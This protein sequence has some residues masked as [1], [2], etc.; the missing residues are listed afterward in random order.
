MNNI[1]FMVLIC[2]AT[3]QL[4][5]IYGTQINTSWKCEKITTERLSNGR[6]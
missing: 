2:L 5:H 1:I 6:A 3:F 4:G